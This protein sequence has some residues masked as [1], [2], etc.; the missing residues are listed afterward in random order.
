[1]AAG[2]KREQQWKSQS[3]R[4]RAVSQT[5]IEQY[6]TVREQKWSSVWDSEQRERE[7]EREQYMEMIDKIEAWDEERDKKEEMEEGGRV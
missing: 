5:D 3:D 6:G 4:H 7:R 1:M 2:H